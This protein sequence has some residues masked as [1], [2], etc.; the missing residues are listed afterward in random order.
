MYLN[1][2][3][4]AYQFQSIRPFVVSYIRPS[5]PSKILPLSHYQAVSIT[6]YC[7]ASLITLLSVW[8]HTLFAQPT[9]FLSFAHYHA[10]LIAFSIFRHGRLSFLLIV[11][12]R[13]WHNPPISL[14]S[15]TSHSLHSFKALHPLKPVRLLHSESGRRRNSY[16]YPKLP[17]H[18]SEVMKVG[19]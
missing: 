6:H 19:G 3:R 2:L 4:T 7:P 5:L 10:V 14:H 8:T 11:L 15:H 9:N 17:A 16:H 13:P 1:V 12:N 18:Y